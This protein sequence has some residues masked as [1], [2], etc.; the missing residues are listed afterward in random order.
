MNSLLALNIFI[1]SIVD[2]LHRGMGFQRCHLELSKL[3]KLK[4]FMAMAVHILQLSSPTDRPVHVTFIYGDL[5]SK[6]FR[7][8]LLICLESRR[9][10]L[11]G[12]LLCFPRTTTVHE[13]RWRAF[14]ASDAIRVLLVPLP[15]Q[16]SQA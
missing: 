3:L 12:S 9:K 11:P 10:I 8:K 7:D 5:R 1:K 14:I 15:I 16:V 13:S 2:A 4:P 6:K